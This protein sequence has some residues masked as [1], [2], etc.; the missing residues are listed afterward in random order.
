MQGCAGGI[1]VVKVFI[2]ISVHRIAP[3][4]KAGAVARLKPSPK[5]SAAALAPTK[6]QIE[7]FDVDR[8]D[9]DVLN[10]NLSQEAG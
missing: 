6:S 8:H 3:P 10:F 7:N 1:L 4:F 2:I 5:P 9:S